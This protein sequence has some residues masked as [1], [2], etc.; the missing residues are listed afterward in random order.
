M[1]TKQIKC[2]DCKRETCPQRVIGA[3]CSLNSE[4]TPLINSLGSRD[5]IL[6]SE[7]IVSMV[8]SEYERYLKAKKMESI[9]TKKKKQLVTKLGDVVEVK[10]E[11]SINNNVSNLAMNIIKSGKILNE[12]MNPPKNTP[13]LQQNNQ[14]NI[15]MSAV[16]Q[17]RGL[18]EEERVKAL[19]F[20]DD[21]LDAKREN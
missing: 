2:D 13:F 10:V 11:N 19:K 14:Y 6:V 18:P 8:G 21:K 15:K 16:D 9:G 1:A 5:P 17:I 12:I 7:F 20:I 4:L 3:V